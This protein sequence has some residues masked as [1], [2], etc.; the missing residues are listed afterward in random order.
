MWSLD[1]LDCIL[2]FHRGGRAVHN[3]A[4]VDERRA[5]PITIFRI[6]IV[7]VDGAVVLVVVLAAGGVIWADSRRLVD[8]VAGAIDSCTTVVTDSVCSRKAH[9]CEQG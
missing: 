4:V 6:H 5:V 3:I 2:A 1:A 7:R 9:P 8:A